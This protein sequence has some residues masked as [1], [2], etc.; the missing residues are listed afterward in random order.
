[1]ARV[2]LIRPRSVFG[3]LVLILLVAA[4]DTTE[5][6][7]EGHFESALA[8]IADGD[9][10]RAK[11]ELRTVFSLVP[12]HV[13]ARETLAEILLEEG[14][15]AG[16]FGQYMRLVEQLP[17]ATEPRFVVTEL[18]ML[19]LEFEDA[20]VHLD[21]LQELAPADPRTAALQNAVS[22]RS[23][24]IEEDVIARRSSAAKAL[25]LVAD[26]PN[27]LLNSTVV[28]DN[29]VL[30]ADFDGLFEEL[31]RI[32]AIFP[33]ERRIFQ[34]RLTGYSRMGDFEGIERTIRSM[35]E[36]FPEDE[37]LPQTLMRYYADR[38][39][40][41]GAE[42]FLRDR[43]AVDGSGDAERMTLLRYLT[44]ARD[45]QTALDETRRLI[46][47]GTNNQLFRSVEASLLYDLGERDAA[48]AIFEDIVAT[49]DP[50]D[51][52][53]NIKTTY[54]GL[55]Q[56]DGNEVGARA[57]IEGVLETD[58][59]HVPSLLMRAHWLME[60]D[61][62]DDAVLA[63]RLAQDQEPENPEIFA[64]LAEAHLRN[65]ERLLAG[66]ML[67]L[68]VE[69]SNSAP[70]HAVGYARYLT[71]DARLA[72]AEAVLIKA[73]RLAPRDVTILVALGEVYVAMADWGRAQGVEDKLR[74][75][76]ADAQANT[77]R[78]EALRAQ[79]RTDDAV[80]FLE[81]LSADGA[82][83]L[84]AEIAIAQTLIRDGD[85][86]A[87]LTHLQDA[88]AANTEDETLRFFVASAQAVTGDHAAAAEGYRQLID[89]GATG[90]R[91][92]VELIRA[93]KRSG[94]GDEAA[95]ELKA[96]LERAP[97]APDLLWMRASELE[98]AG[99]TDGAIEIY[100]TLYA[101]NSASPIVANNLA[102]LLSTSRSDA[103]SL[104]RAERI[105]R[106]L[107]ETEIPAFQDTYGWIQYLS[108]NYTEAVDYL[109]AAARA[110]PDDPLVQAHLGLTYAAL[111]R[112]E[113]AV[114]RLT[115][116]I[117][118]AGDDSRLTLALA[119]ERLAE[120]QNR[121]SAE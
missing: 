30:D 37:V 98:A 26:L 43:I 111:E 81:R 56:R 85:A 1:M 89:D 69:T 66:E 73:L 51:Q 60:D 10:A 92:W 106:R 68:A 54:A 40:L 84:A 100:E 119:R 11:V 31:D 94:R 91:V 112:S 109:E 2:S 38:G 25:Q 27:S 44:T 95:V 116:A 61:R 22:Y 63:L 67:A 35:I 48:V 49:A 74:E 121:D 59:S 64:R 20:Q 29:A 23:A 102:S 78:L 7:A 83:G 71:R 47:E 3:V 34:Y 76:G 36:T 99:D 13:P 75:I 12:D 32:Q 103:E 86:P 21:V 70:L 17:D 79:G 101:A 77:L 4:C 24:V 110:L 45:P 50:S 72:P 14:D 6:R 93:L 80:A 46:E 62:A 88:L 108:G 87:A 9:V 53:N 105:A 52:T 120:L 18:L 39:D 114:A 82:A 16:A 28:A 65:G 117:D 8:L 97:D 33:E 42:T 115:Q 96:A 104:E 41:D 57:L 107:R 113:D 55:L 58:P 5:E 15:L 19:D 90:A 118:L